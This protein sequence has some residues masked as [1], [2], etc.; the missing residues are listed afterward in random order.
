MAF[1]EEDSVWTDDIY[2]LNALGPNDGGDPVQGG[3]PVIVS[4][5]PTEGHA[6]AQA[7]Q[8]ADRT[9]YLKDLVGDVTSQG[10][11][12]IEDNT[13]A[14]QRDTLGLGTA[15][16][17]DVTT[18][19]DDTTTE[20]V[21]VTGS[22]GIAGNT[23]IT[24]NFNTVVGGGLYANTDTAAVGLALP[25]ST[26]ITL[27]AERSSTIAT[28][29]QMRSGSGDNIYYR[30]KTSGTW[31]P[32][33]ELFHSGNL[34]NSTDTTKGA[35]LV[36]YFPT[37][38]GAV[39]R[40]LRDRLSDSVSV[41]DFGAIGN[42][43]ADDYAAF[44]AALAA[45]DS[46][47]VPPGR[48]LIGTGN[49]SIGQKRL[50]ATPGLS[51]GTWAAMGTTGAVIVTTQTTNSVFIGGNGTVIDGLHFHYP[52]QDGTSITDTS[53]YPTIVGNPI[54]YPASIAFPT[55]G[56]NWVIRNCN[57]LNSYECISAGDTAIVQG[58]G[59]GVIDNCSAFVIKYFFRGYNLLD[60][61]IVSNFTL[62]PG[63]I[64]GASADKEKLYSWALRNARAFEINKADGL[65]ID[66]GII[67]GVDIG[68]SFIG[69][70]AH[71][72]GKIRGVTLDGSRRFMDSAVTMSGVTISDCQ[73][74]CNTKHAS[75]ETYAPAIYL[76]GPNAPS[77]G[78]LQLDN[79]QVY[80]CLGEVIKVQGSGSVVPFLK[81][82]NYA[83]FGW[84][85]G[86]DTPADTSAVLIDASGTHMHASEGFLR[87]GVQTITAFRITS[88]GRITIDNNEMEGGKRFA[89][90]NN[91]SFVKL[92]N[93]RSF[94]TD[95]GTLDV[96]TSG[97]ITELYQRGNRFS[98]PPTTLV[99]NYPNFEARQSGAQTLSTGSTSIFATENRD[100]DS[101]F[102][103]AT[104][105]FTCKTPGSYV[106]N[107]NLTL[108]TGTA[109]DVWA[110][111]L[112]T[113]LRTYQSRITIGTGTDDRVV[114][115]NTIAE[116]RVGDTA[117][118]VA[119]RPVGSGTFVT[120]VAPNENFFAGRL[121]D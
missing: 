61:V 76:H 89:D 93:N 75:V 16:V 97:T 43:V 92:S 82:V 38:T 23:V 45:S 10:R 103:V 85:K 51:G 30:R 57:F 116:M 98:V 36:G 13:A 47:Y 115:I 60:Q 84:G 94:T 74:L 24:E 78:D 70:L 46:V 22:H 37:F 80:Q 113:T 96:T 107:C 14:E 105:I 119:Q 8:L 6:N 59:R 102:D 50:W 5:V 44:V 42:G 86:T 108:D 56:A 39:G 62:S 55:G 88:G 18:S 49:I 106:F 19:N 15:A 29:L 33:V 100:G 4:G 11:E 53:G 101:S 3:T 34:S 35:N 118:I 81:L 17:A 20:R 83:F 28:Q 71:S 68:F 26:A 67:Y 58:C 25:G 64:A 27:H 31:Q 66:T 117:K 120:T 63:I 87:P 1:I 72:L 65:Q 54:V 79:V 12:L 21:L 111:Q 90:L 121:I 112:V 7:K 40:S 41:K 99:T 2:L 104:G 109:A 95:A 52:N 114:T 110:I 77:F 69:S 32:A 9:L 73:L 48:Y 91:A